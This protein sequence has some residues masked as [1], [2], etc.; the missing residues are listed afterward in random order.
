MF[1]MEED[2]VKD[3]FHNL[4]NMEE[5]DVISPH[6]VVFLNYIE[7]PE[8]IATEIGVTQLL[9]VW[10]YNG[11][12]IMKYIRP[13]PQ[14]PIAHNL[15][16]ILIMLM[17]VLNKPAVF[18]IPDLSWVTQDILTLLDNQ[19]S[20]MAKD[21]GFPG[22]SDKQKCDMM[23]SLVM[24]QQ[25]PELFKYT[26]V[27]IVDRI[28][29]SMD[30]KW[31]RSHGLHHAHGAFT[32]IN[33]VVPRPSFHALLQTLTKDVQAFHYCDDFIAYGHSRKCNFR[34]GNIILRRILE[35]K[36]VVQS[37]KFTHMP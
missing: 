34:Q 37:K 14:R 23:R 10:T 12:L 20:I 21:P 36:I 31:K 32:L 2:D 22:F 26:Y 29:Y 16:P 4:F 35:L 15:L 13:I 19:C 18:F 24:A 1:N 8:E 3:M 11:L 17:A 5:D 7:V 28:A 9:H 30:I 25:C 27:Y 33:G 6:T